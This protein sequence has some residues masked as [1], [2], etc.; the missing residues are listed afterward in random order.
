MAPKPIAS[1]TFLGTHQFVFLGIAYT[2]EK[3]SP[4]HEVYLML[5]RPD[6]P[7]AL[8]GQ[9]L[10]AMSSPDATQVKRMLMAGIGKR[11]RDDKEMPLPL[12]TW[13]EYLTVEDLVL[14]IAP[15][16]PGQPPQILQRATLIVTL[17]DENDLLTGR[18]LHQWLRLKQC[19]ARFTI[20]APDGQL[21]D[22][23]I[24]AAWEA[25]FRR[26]TPQLQRRLAVATF[27]QLDAHLDAGEELTKEDI[28]LFRQA[29]GRQTTSAVIPGG[30]HPVAPEEAPPISPAPEPGDPD[31]EFPDVFEE[32]L[33]EVQKIAEVPLDEEVPDPDLIADLEETFP[34]LPDA[35][36]MPRRFRKLAE[37]AEVIV[38]NARQ[39]E[40]LDEEEMKTVQKAL[41]PFDE[42]RVARRAK[43]VGK[44]FQVIKGIAS[45]AMDPT[46]GPVMGILSGVMGAIKSDGLE[47]EP[48]GKMQQLL[49]VAGSIQQRVG[50]GGQVVDG[51]LQGEL[52]GL[53]KGLARDKMG[54]GEGLR[55]KLGA[56]KEGL[57]GG[58]LL[59][60]VKEKVEEKKAELVER[61]EEKVGEMA[62]GISERNEE[63]AREPTR[64][65]KKRRK[66][67]EEPSKT[68]P[69]P[70]PNQEPIS[71]TGIFGGEDASEDAPGADFADLE[72][73]LEEVRRQPKEPS[74]RI[75]PANAKVNPPARNRREATDASEAA[76]PDPQPMD[77]S[78]LTAS[79]P[80]SQTQQHQIEEDGPS[81]DPEG[82]ENTPLVS[83]DD[84]QEAAQ[85]AL[86]AIA[87]GKNP[88]KALGGFLRRK[89]EQLPLGGAD[90][91]PEIIGTNLLDYDPDDE[92]PEENEPEDDDRRP[93]SDNYFDDNDDDDPEYDDED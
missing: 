66:K 68:E 62:A 54:K 85:G 22:E 74:R 3:P 26:T 21:L 87:G 80:Q 82:E 77:F 51:A 55:G 58:G 89:K 29:T 35:S 10:A 88:L 11:F 79:E 9:Q 13:L 90:D 40:L 31:Y 57:G 32:L 45:G 63:R 72:K 38:S 14:A 73:Q 71:E 8:T 36:A 39:F 5:Q 25:Y 6:P 60:Q 48:G 69:Q 12:T 34:K 2:L 92:G 33:F 16:A 65:K 37:A 18:P 64:W 52:Q 91:V 46:K 17:R 75:V 78:D 86:E 30:A 41:R 47:Q 1:G 27:H 24:D 70:E 50:Q 15:T 83:A 7:Q 81:E 56:V 43:I 93:F 23:F 44:A 84:A 49:Q 28:D 76:S 20:D 67:A 19:S 59:D 4:D 61:V 53:L 42:H